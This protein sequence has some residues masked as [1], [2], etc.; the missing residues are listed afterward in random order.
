[1]RSIDS[2]I[3][4][5]LSLLKWLWSGSINARGDLRRVIVFSIALLVLAGGL[6][7]CS[8]LTKLI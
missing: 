4:T 8:R 3:L 1:M 5:L 2:Q 6:F 7:I